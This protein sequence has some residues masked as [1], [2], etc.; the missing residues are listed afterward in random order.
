M[1]ASAKLRLDF[2]Q[3]SPHPLA[4]RLAPHRIAPLPV[5]P[6]DMREPQKIE[7]LGLAFS[8]LVPVDLGMPPELHPARFVGG[9]VPARTAAAV[10]GVPPGSGRPRPCTGNREHYRPRIGQP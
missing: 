3:L 7:R 10:P 2:K 4:D 5:L 6:A 9:A 8:S 1:P